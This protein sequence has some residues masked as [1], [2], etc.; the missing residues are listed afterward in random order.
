M[1]EEDRLPSISEDAYSEECY[2]I[3]VADGEGDG[4]LP[5]TVAPFRQSSDRILKLF[6][7]DDESL[8]WKIKPNKDSAGAFSKEPRPDMVALTRNGN[9]WQRRPWQNPAELPQV[10][11]P[12]DRSGPVAVASAPGLSDNDQRARNL[13]ALRDNPGFLAAMAARQSGA[14]SRR[15]ISGQG[16]HKGKTPEPSHLLPAPR[17]SGSNPPGDSDDGKDGNSESLPDFRQQDILSQAKLE[18]AI[19]KAKNP[20]ANRSDN[21]FKNKMS[22]E[23]VQF[24]A[25]YE[26]F[27]G[28]NCEQLFAM[29]KA[30][31][32]VLYSAYVQAVNEKCGD[33]VSAIAPTYWHK[34]AQN[35]GLSCATPLACKA[36]VAEKCGCE[37]ANSGCS[38]SCLATELFGVTYNDFGYGSLKVNG[39]PGCLGETEPPITGLAQCH[40]EMLT[41]YFFKGFG[42]GSFGII[43]SMIGVSAKGNK[44]G[45]VV[46]LAY[47]RFRQA[48]A[49]GLLNKCAW[50]KVA[51]DCGKKMV[52]SDS[53]GGFSYSEYFDVLCNKCDP[54]YTFP[55]DKSCNCWALNEIA[56]GKET[57]FKVAY[58]LCA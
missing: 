4:V 53:L 48:W 54:E 31:Q 32:A 52:L 3:L 25:F 24:A 35:C 43:G 5:P 28:A 36:L 17:S 50:T 19:W 49:W 7:D 8:L 11:L 56:A 20:F 14:V 21:L 41:T 55:G 39:Q 29:L 40:P 1:Y 22:P 13:A 10:E 23:F 51:F 30:S 26:G 18:A 15:P 33:T 47:W 37:V 57:W 38:A 9:D 12:T 44:F 45:S 42:P 27:Y 2:N 6:A 34:V 58:N 46:D 16:G